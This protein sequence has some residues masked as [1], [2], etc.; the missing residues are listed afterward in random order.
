MGTKFTLEKA[1]KQNIPK[2]PQTVLVWNRPKNS[3]LDH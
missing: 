2:G 3:G 1:P